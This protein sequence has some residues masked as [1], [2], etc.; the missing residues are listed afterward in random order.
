MDPNREKE[1]LEISSYLKNYWVKYKEAPKTVVNFY[2]IGKILG[3]GA[4][5]KVHLGIHKLTGKFVAIKLIHKQLM[6]DE[7]SKR[8]VMREVAIWE[9]LAHS[10]VIRLYETF[11]S[12]KYLLYVEELCA[13]G[14][15]LSYVRKRRKLKEPAAKAIFKQI[16][17]GIYYC[18][19]K[20]ILHR[21]IKLD[22]ILLDAEG[23]VKICDFGVSKAMKAGEVMTERC[24]TPAYIAPEILKREGYSGFA[25]DVWSAGVVLY[26]MLYGAVPFR[27]GC[28][29]ELH[30]LILKRKCKF[31]STIS[32]EARSLLHKILEVD[33]K[34]RYSI[35]QILCHEWFSN[36]DPEVKLFT[37]SEKES[38]KSDFANARK[39]FRNQPLLPTES[40]WFVEQNIDV[41]SSEL[42]RNVTARSLVLAPFN[43]TE[44]NSGRAE[45]ICDRRVIKFGAKV[46]EIDRQYEKNN[47]CEVDNGVYNE[48]WDKSDDS[49][50]SS[51]SDD[52]L[53]DEIILINEPLPKPIDQSI[54]NLL[55]DSLA[56]KQAAV[57][58]RIVNCI[59]ELGYPK[60]YVMEG[61][62]KSWRNYATTSYFLLSK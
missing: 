1:M 12:E 38:L 21:D 46:K 25:S 9:K 37:D 22:N 30:A 56:P 39:T 5:G 10:N 15:L 44:R 49:S 62:E 35:Q 32:E 59:A 26:T 27:A 42:T 48:C 8:K 53:E 34:K 29:A 23:E 50:L 16:L 28:M 41:S 57:D 19:S 7:T 61:L 24:G 45:E 2:K 55:L 36:Y 40:D 13:G 14:D 18:H 31:K 11:E 54:K 51:D 20:G 47:N 6:K 60:E 52:S 33:P 43:T 3:K 17:N 4:F 58:K